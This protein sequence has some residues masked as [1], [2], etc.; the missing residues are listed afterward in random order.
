M[1]QAKTPTVRSWEVYEKQKRSGHLFQG[2]YQAVL[3]ENEE[4]L[5]HVSRYIHLNPL[6]AGLV[7]L[8][9]LTQFSHSSLSQYA[10][11]RPLGSVL[12]ETKEILHRFRNE[13]DYL[14]FVLDQADYAKSLHKNL[15]LYMDE[16]LG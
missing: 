7:S 13:E 4:Q 16:D 9:E 5:V 3:I 6:V 1:K 12:V 2:R 11:N 15:R 10:H 14:A 8:G